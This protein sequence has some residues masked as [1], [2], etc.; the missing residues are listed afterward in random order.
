[1]SLE[2]NHAPTGPEDPVGLT[3]EQAQEFHQ[4]FMKSFLIFVAVAVV[5][6]VLAWAWRP[7]LPG[8]NGYASLIDGVHAV[9]P[10]LA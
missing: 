4:L 2:S 8:A 3:E 7:W 6:H 5:A 9:I 10:H 1:M